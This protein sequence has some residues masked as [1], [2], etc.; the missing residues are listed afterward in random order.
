MELSFAAQQVERIAGLHFPSERSS[1]IERGLKR[2]QARFSLNNLHEALDLLRN[3]V[4]SGGV[5][6]TEIATCFTIGETHFYRDHFVFDQL[7]T[8]FLKWAADSK[9]LDS[10][11][12]I[13]CA[14][15]ST[16]EEAYTLAALIA[17]CFT[18][19][20]QKRV[21]LLATDINVDSLARAKR[22]VYSKWSFR[23]VPKSF[24]ELNFKRISDQEWEVKPHLRALVRFENFN[25]VTG[26]C[27]SEPYHLILCRNVIM[28]FTTKTAQGVV[29]KLLDVLRPGGLFF[30]AAAE[31][32]LVED[33]EH[34]DW[35]AGVFRKRRT[36]AWLSLIWKVRTCRVLRVLS[37]LTR[38]QWRLSSSKMI[39][40]RSGLEHKSVRMKVSLRS[41]FVFVLS[42]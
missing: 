39:S 41:L 30:V 11:L 5:E 3:E 2:L 42:F 23:D 27:S 17:K 10:K 31:A 38:R 35:G 40:T 14:A 21:E 18:A 36:Q 16:G 34:L 24:R 15:C 1:D 28:Y 12:R 25:L 29:G 22:G 33:C 19:E 26:P 32:W 7:T 6:S 9:N 37:G 4:D 20:Q 13:W 8:W